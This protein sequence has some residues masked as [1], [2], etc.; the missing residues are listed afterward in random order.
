MRKKTPKKTQNNN[1]KKQPNTQPRSFSQPQLSRSYVALI[2]SI[3]K[4]KNPELS[5]SKRT[6][7][8]LDKGQTLS[9]ADIFSNAFPTPL[10]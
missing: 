6:A 5:N 1:P 9:N 4:V 10:R 2:S 8:C 3:N 7:L